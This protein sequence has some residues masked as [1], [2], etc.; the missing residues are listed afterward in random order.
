MNPVG[1]RRGGYVLMVALLFIMAFL[2][3]AFLFLFTNSR[4]QIQSVQNVRMSRQAQEGIRGAVLEDLNRAQTDFYQDHFD[5]VVSGF[6]AQGNPRPHARS[7]D[8]ALSTYKTFKKGGRRHY[9]GFHYLKGVMEFRNEAFRFGLVVENGLVIGPSSPLNGRDLDMGVYVKGALDL[10]EA[11]L[12]IESRPVL[13][14]GDVTGGSDVKLKNRSQLYYS[15]RDHGGWHQVRGNQYDMVP[16]MDLI[17][18]DLSVYRTKFRIY[19]NVSSEPVQSATWTFT[20]V[21]PD[22]CECR[23]GPDPGDVWPVAYQPNF[24]W[25]IFVL[26]GGNLIV[27]GQCSSKVTVVSYSRTPSNLE[28]NIFINGD[29]G[30]IPSG[31]AVSAPT[32][33]FA[34]LASRQITFN[35]GSGQKVF[36]YYYAQTF[37]VVPNPGDGNNTDVELRGTLHATLGLSPVVPGN[38][39]RILFDPDLSANNPP[40]IPQRPLLVTFHNR[41]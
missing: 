23:F 21:T 2:L 20:Q 25:P 19:S 22:T 41:R 8:Y 18:M 29:F 4:R 39:L 10:S 9:D 33:S 7:R 37:D 13:V 28:G 38:T 14:E 31:G 11:N 3:P 32:R 36:G 30:Q 15:G 26:E 16:P 12:D 17:E 5:R 40:G 35:G 1:E 27:Q 34:A 6:S 24:G